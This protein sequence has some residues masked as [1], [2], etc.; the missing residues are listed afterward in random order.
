MYL[1]CFRDFKN[2]LGTYHFADGEKHREQNASEFLL[3]FFNKIKL[4]TKGKC[5]ISFSTDT[6]KLGNNTNMYLY[7]IISLKLIVFM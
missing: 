7:K 2:I 5:F 6:D 1:M 4:E 3:F